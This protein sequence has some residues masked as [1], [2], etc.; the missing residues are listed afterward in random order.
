[1]NYCQYMLRIGMSGT[2]QN[3]ID[4]DAGITGWGEEQE[5][6]TA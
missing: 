2:P 5:L 4:E 1:M 6:S 3:I